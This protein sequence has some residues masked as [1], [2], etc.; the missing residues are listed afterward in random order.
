M[1]SFDEDLD[2]AR[3][4]SR[5]LTNRFGIPSFFIRFYASYNW[6]EYK[7]AQRS[8]SSSPLHLQLIM[9][10]TF[11]EKVREVI[12]EIKKSN[13]M[14]EIVAISHTVEYKQGSIPYALLLVYI[15]E[16]SRSKFLSSPK[17]IDK[18]ISAEIPSYDL[19]DDKDWEFMASFSTVQVHTPCG[20]GINP[21]ASC[22]VNGRCKENFPRPFSP[23]TILKGDPLNK[24]KSPIYKRRKEAG[25]F[26]LPD[27][28]L[29][30]NEDFPLDSGWVIPYNLHF[31]KLFGSRITFDFLLDQID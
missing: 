17:N 15:T 9:D 7:K 31:S 25:T 5:D 8:M 6:D 30:N 14:G 21:K 24:N 11:M 26:L 27:L 20:P 13:D 18:V 12:R 19:D 10:K 16:E 29:K 1:T 2:N 3:N 28:K 23:N 22:I 4:K